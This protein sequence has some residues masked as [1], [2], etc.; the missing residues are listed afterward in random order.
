[1]NDC[2]WCGTGNGICA[3]CMAKL[4]EESAKI[5]ESGEHLAKDD[6]DKK[7]EAA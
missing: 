6:D 2:A 5:A 3:D 7:G 1:M 4:L